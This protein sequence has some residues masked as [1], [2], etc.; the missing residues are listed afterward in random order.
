MELKIAAKPLNRSP[1]NCVSAVFTLLTLKN[2][3]KPLLDF[4]EVAQ[5][6]CVGCTNCLNCWVVFFFLLF[7]PPSHSVELKIIAIHTQSRTEHSRKANKQ[8]HSVWKRREKKKE[9]TFPDAHVITNSIEPKESEAVVFTL[10]T[11]RSSCMRRF[12]FFH[13]IFFFETFKN[14]INY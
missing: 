4:E 7:W 13:F 14:L 8:T 5:H 3:P 10:Y 1:I 2:P 6:K 9:E 12:F 11:S